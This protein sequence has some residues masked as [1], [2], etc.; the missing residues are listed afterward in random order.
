MNL[1]EILPRL[2]GVRKGG[3]GFAAKCP[4]HDDQKQSLNLAEANGRVLVKCY[5]GCDTMSVVSALGLT[6]QDLFDRGITN[7][8]SSSLGSTEKRAH[9]NNNN[10]HV[11]NNSR[12]HAV[13]HY[14]DEAGE[15]LYENVRYHPKG[16][17]QRRFDERGNAVWNLEGVRRV[18]Y[19]LP[20][21]IK[22]A[23]QGTDVFLC[24][25]E[26]DADALA[27]LGFI[28]TSFKNWTDDHNQFIRG[29][30][31]II[32]QDHDVP[33]VTMASEAARRVLGS[34]ASVKILDVF[35]GRDLPEKHGLDIS[36][37][38][39]I[40]VQDEGQDA[41][42]IKE[43][44]CLMISQ[45]D[46]WRDTANR[47]TDN[48]FVV[49]SGNE[50]MSQSKSQAI[51]KKLFGEFWFENELCILFAD[52]N[53]GKSILA[54]QIADRI[55]RGQLVVG[56]RQSADDIE[57]PTANCQLPTDCDGQKVVYFDFELTAKQFES[58]FSERE[59]G[60]DE[61]VNHYEFHRNFYRAEINPESSD[62]GGFA[63]F[64][65]FLNNALETTVVSS[66]TKVLIIDNLTYL[67]D[68]TENARNALPLMKFLKSLKSK[69]GLSIL[70][71]AHTPKRDS[72]KPLGRNDLQ[73][74]KMLINFCDSSFAIGESAKNVGMRYLKQIK[75]RN[76]EI[77]YHTENVL[78]ANIAKAGNFLHFEFHGSGAEQEHLK[79]FSDKQRTEL[80]EQVKQLTAKG[81]SQRE[82]AEQLGISQMSVSR[83]LKNNVN[84]TA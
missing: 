60:S 66:G 73:G 23:E 43:R 68:E 67:R 80:I 35:A 20:E 69:H 40:S 11:P 76:T 10:G 79:V 30:H 15:L 22:G 12:I 50:W 3:Q 82:V 44:V 5:A 29:T 49:Q 13:Y 84:Q 47:K 63:K 81:K 6:W 31:V 21:L 77:I 72:S 74:S 46:V 48:Y 41:D 42:S 62:I 54:V 52:T 17:R 25:G 27:E 32:V 8:S 1:R 65:E 7:P 33:G 36:D 70:A 9:T 56:G 57:L 71:L 78:M 64:E 37:Y 24:E 4:A 18:P 45:T 19:R 39:R 58:R 55:S 28:A 53:V 83:Y 61:F 38:I 16:F 2:S 51:P 75:A 59:E 14:V 26:K 34:A